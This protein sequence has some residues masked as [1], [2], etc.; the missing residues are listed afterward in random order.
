MVNRLFTENED[1]LDVVLADSNPPITVALRA[2]QLKLPMVSP[3]WV[4]Q[5]RIDCL[6]L[7]HEVTLP[8]LTD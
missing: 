6:V 5:V 1:R 4:I 8:T 3:H 7:W 2:Q